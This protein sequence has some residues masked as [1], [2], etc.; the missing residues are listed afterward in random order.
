[1]LKIY[2]DENLFLNL[3]CFHVLFSLREDQQLKNNKVLSKLTSMHSSTNVTE[4]TY[5]TFRYH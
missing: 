1:M 2:Y 4:Q 3:Q 5:I